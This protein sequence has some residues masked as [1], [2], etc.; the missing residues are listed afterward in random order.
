LTLL[1]PKNMHPIGAGRQPQGAPLGW[2][3]RRRLS[4][5]GGP[6]C[7]NPTS[8]S[9]VFHGFDTFGLEKGPGNARVQPFGD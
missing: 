4:A 8:L 1:P 7:G 3:S 2:G 6:S 5:G 9:S